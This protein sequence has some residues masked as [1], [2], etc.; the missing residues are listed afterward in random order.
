[1]VDLLEEQRF[2]PRL[3]R[4]GIVKGISYPKKI[5]FTYTQTTNKPKMEKIF[6][7]SKLEMGMLI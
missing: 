5:L 3:N 6:L 7:G 4:N 2:I 1:V